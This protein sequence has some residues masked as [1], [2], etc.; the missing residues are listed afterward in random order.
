MYL[1]LYD[2]ASYGAI[3]PKCAAIAKKQKE[4]SSICQKNPTKC[5]EIIA[6]LCEKY[7]T[8]LQPPKKWNSVMFLMNRELCKAGI[9]CPEGKTKESYAEGAGSVGDA[10]SS[11]SESD[12]ATSIMDYIKQYWLYGAIGVAIIAGIVYFKKR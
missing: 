1:K 10:I 8:G 4:V 3:D 12:T 5:D 11:I 6:K 7:E 9:W 2:T